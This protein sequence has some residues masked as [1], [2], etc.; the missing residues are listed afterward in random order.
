M[1]F[2]KSRKSIGDEASPLD[3]Q[4]VLDGKYESSNLTASVEKLK[5]KAD[6]EDEDVI[7][8]KSLN[9]Q[10]LKYYSVES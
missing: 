9:I 7:K 5:K 4:M 3:R 1:D 10:K 8:K 2:R 6:S